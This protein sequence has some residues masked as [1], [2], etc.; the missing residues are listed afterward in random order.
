[1]DQETLKALP[2]GLYIVTLKEELGLAP[3][4]VKLY[5]K[6]TG[7]RSEALEAAES[8]LDGARTAA[9]LES[10]ADSFREA[11]R[12]IPL[13]PLSLR[14]FGYGEWDGGDFTPLDEADFYDISPVVLTPKHF[15]QHG[16]LV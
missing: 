9:D 4:L 2:D 11:L 15:D 10:F 7:F 16:R 14:G 3:K 13:E 1:V 8:A 5:N 12:T 6:T